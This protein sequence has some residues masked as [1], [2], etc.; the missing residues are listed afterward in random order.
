MNPDTTRAHEPADTSENRNQPMMND[1]DPIAVGDHKLMLAQ[2]TTGTTVDEATSA[3]LLPLRPGIV[4][5]PV[6]VATVLHLHTDQPE[7]ELT[8]AAEDEHELRELLTDETAKAEILAEAGRIWRDRYDPDD[9]QPHPDPPRL[10][11][12]LEDASNRDEHQRILEDLLTVRIPTRISVPRSK[13]IKRFGIGR[14][15]ATL[16]RSHLRHVLDLYRSGDMHWPKVQAWASTVLLH[17]G[18]PV[19]RPYV[20]IE[21]GARTDLVVLLSI[22]SGSEPRHADEDRALWAL[23]C[24]DPR[25]WWDSPWG[26]A[27]GAVLAASAGIWAA[28]TWDL[29]SE[30]TP[31]HLQIAAIAAAIPAAFAFST[32]ASSGIRAAGRQLEFW[33]ALATVALWAVYVL[34]LPLPR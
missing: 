22:M 28:T 11:Q 14:P 23:A 15:L 32:W 19:K 8:S 6:A 10:V 21:P 34:D 4:I 9:Y 3:V 1:L 5:E 30:V 24:D 31:G 25:R 12:A 2:R 16:R 26:A 20:A 27:L 7:L 29:P 17:I 33:L 13:Q 18:A